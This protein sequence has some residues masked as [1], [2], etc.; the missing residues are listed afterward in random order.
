MYI[1][2]I[3]VYLLQLSNILECT[4]INS[5]YQKIHIMI[6]STYIKYKYT[7]YLYILYIL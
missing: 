3:F 5:V 7:I 6:V 4:L 1:L 2:Y